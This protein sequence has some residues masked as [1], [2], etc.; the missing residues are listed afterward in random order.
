MTHY[1]GADLWPD[2]AQIQAES[3]G[4]SLILL[5]PIA[6]AL[7]GVGRSLPTNV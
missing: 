4:V 7:I 2:L 6:L 3:I 1:I 5:C